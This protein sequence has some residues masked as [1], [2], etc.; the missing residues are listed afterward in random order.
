MPKDFDPYHRWLGIRP[1]EQPPDHYRLLGL[2]RFEDDPEV[3]RDAAE[4]Q[5]AHVRGYALGKYSDLSQRILNELGKAKACLLDEQKRAA[6]DREL[7]QQI[8]IEREDAAAALPKSEAAAESTRVSTG[9]APSAPHLPLPTTRRRAVSRHRPRSIWRSPIAMGGAVI[10][11]LACVLG[12]VL[13]VSSMASRDGDGGF[14]EDDWDRAEGRQVTRPQIQTSPKSS[15]TAAPAADVTGERR[16][17]RQAPPPPKETRSEPPLAIAPFDAEAAKQH[18]RAWA[19]YLDDPVE[20]TNT[21]GMT[22]VLIPPGEFDMG[23]PQEE[24]ERLVAEAKAEKLPNWYIERLP[25]EAPKHRVWIT[26]PFWLGRHEVTRGQFRRF[27]DDRG[28]ETQAERDGKGGFG[29][30]NGKQVQDPRFVWNADPGFSQTDDHPVVHVSWND[31]V[32]FCEWLSD[33]EGV[34]CHLATEAQWEYACRAGTTT[35]WHCGDDETTLEKYAWYSVNSGRMTHPV[36]QLRPN[37]WG[38]CDM[39]G[40]VWEWCHDWRA[41]DYY[42]MSPLEDPSGP[43]AGSQQVVRGGCWRDMASLRRTSFR[44]GR[45]LGDRDAYLGF[46]VA[47]ESAQASI[48]KARPMMKSETPN[49]TDIAGERNGRAKV[50]QPG[51]KPGPP[52]AKDTPSERE[53]EVRS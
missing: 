51:G 29:W 3:I 1:E 52:P 47:M 34:K 25:G 7:R 22:F 24:V 28:Y 42:G 45:R 30:V 48:A 50:T 36:G 23:A 39:H 6:Y 8:S 11:V 35:S 14:A 53:T 27:V 21:L 2:A 17:P 19:E 26:K 13:W 18:Q 44:G 10:G 41:D 4:R 9:A 46:R 49:R 5:I 16:A 37:A 32:A 15:P 12:G 20:M 43:A 38:L 40:N 31:A 33:K